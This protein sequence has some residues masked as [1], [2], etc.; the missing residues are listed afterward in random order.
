MTEIVIFVRLV[1]FP[2]FIFS[3]FVISDMTMEIF[4]FSKNSTRLKDPFLFPTALSCFF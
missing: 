4:I 3:D 2:N 1:L